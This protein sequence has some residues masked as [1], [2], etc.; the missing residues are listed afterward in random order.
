MDTFLNHKILPDF[1]DR[2]KSLISNE[3]KEIPSLTRIYQKEKLIAE[4]SNE[5]EKNSDSSYHSEIL[6]LREAKERIGTRYLTDCLLIT[7]LEPCLMCAGTI[8]L[9]RIPT[10]V[11]LLPAKQGEGISSL[12]IETIYSRNFF[13]ELIC[14]PANLSKEAFKSFFKARRKKFN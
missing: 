10:V 12:S 5:V 1:L 6:C 9:S 4:S 7:S 2:M 11:Y 3:G 8:L 13:P 14:I